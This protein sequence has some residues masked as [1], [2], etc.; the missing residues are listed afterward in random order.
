MKDDYLS[1]NYNKTYF[2][3]VTFFFLF[4]KKK[5]SVFLKKSQEASFDSQ[6]SV[7]KKSLLEF[8]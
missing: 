4:Q 7:D 6:K 2:Y 1:H 5:F 3:L 8:F